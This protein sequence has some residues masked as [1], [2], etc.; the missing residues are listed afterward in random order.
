MAFN[1]GTDQNDLHRS[2]CPPTSSHCI[3]AKENKVLNKAYIRYFDELI[4]LRVVYI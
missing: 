3:S 2:I 4:V 1:C